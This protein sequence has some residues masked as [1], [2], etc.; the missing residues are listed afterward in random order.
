MSYIEQMQSL[1]HEFEEVHGQEP[2]TT[3]ECFEWAYKNKRWAPRSTDMAQ[4]FNKE[5]TDALRQE[6]RIDA[7]GRKYR[8]KVC[9]KEKIGP[10]QMTLWGD[11]DR[12]TPQFFKRSVHQRRNGVS[13]VC[14][15]LKQ[16]VDHFNEYRDASEPIK[17]ILD[18]TDD[19]AELEASNAI[20]D[21]ETT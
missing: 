11:S 2:T 6:Y 16:D 21:L 14:H 7:S 15:Q 12:V 1:W 18:F 19:V 10:V 13:H 3:R 5:M 17:L 9:I 8:A 4:I 20:E